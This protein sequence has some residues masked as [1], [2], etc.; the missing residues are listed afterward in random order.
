MIIALHDK[1]L[2]YCDIDNIADGVFGHLENG[3]TAEGGVPII[4][5]EEE[6]NPQKRSSL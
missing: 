1:N 2:S 5:E 4:N 6:K 3:S